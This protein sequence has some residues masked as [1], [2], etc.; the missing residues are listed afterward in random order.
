MSRQSSGTLRVQSVHVEAEN[1]T[2][3]NLS[4][5]AYSLKAMP[6][7]AQAELGPRVPFQSHPVAE[8]VRLALYRRALGID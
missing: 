8:A 2:W 1:I 6:L 7:L 4:S 3:R 5:A